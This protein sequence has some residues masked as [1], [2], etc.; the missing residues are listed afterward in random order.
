MEIILWKPSHMGKNIMVEL[1]RDAPEIIKA[2]TDKGWT[3]QQREGDDEVWKRLIMPPRGSYPFGLH[4]PSEKSK[5]T[6]QFKSILKS[7]GINNYYER[8]VMAG[9]IH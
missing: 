6:K 7:L 3:Y 9:E 5:Y 8:I 4:T 2:F 1:D